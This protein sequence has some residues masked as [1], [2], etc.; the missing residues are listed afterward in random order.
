MKMATTTAGLTGKLA[1]HLDHVIEGALAR[2]RVVGTVVLVAL[3]GQIVYRRAAGWADRESRSPMR[4]D[5][6][7]R[8]ASVTKPLISAAALA[9]AESGEL[10]LDEPITKWLPEFRPRLPSGEVPDITPR[11]LLTHTAGLDYGFQPDGGPYRK[12]QISNGLDQPGLTMEEALSRLCS[13]PLLFA[14]G[15]AW[16]YS[17]SVDVLGAVLSRAAGISLPDLVQRLVTGPLGMA[18]TDFQVREPA[19]LATAYVDGM[20]RAIRMNDPHDVP[21]P[22]GVVRFSPAR[23]FDSQ[24]YPSG[25]AGLAGS[26]EDVLKFLE[27]I[28]A[29]GSPILNPRSVELLTTNALPPNVAFIEPGWTFSL[30]V[31]VLRDPT[32]ART[33]HELGTWRG[34]GAY[35]HEYFVSPTRRL[36]VVMCSNT[37]SEGTAG[38]YPMDIRDAVYYALTSES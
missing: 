16:N 34:G 4:E 23:I 28:R 20:P 37:T 9:L 24:S 7:F 17:L 15:S 30:G 6:I 8:L 2:E 10:E 27:A 33:P 19:R 1:R 13:V 5:T 18:D 31:I 11:H 25:G 26:A 38:A 29:G 36:S 12:A 14:P 21:F 3:G 32:I 35:G 22:A